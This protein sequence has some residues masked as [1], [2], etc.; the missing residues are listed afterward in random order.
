MANAFGD[1]SQYTKDAAQS[2]TWPG[3]GWVAKKLGGGGVLGC[4]DK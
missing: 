2:A 3:G 4:S 1:D